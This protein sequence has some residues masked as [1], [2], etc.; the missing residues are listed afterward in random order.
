M[1]LNDDGE[2]TRLNEEEKVEEEEEMKGGR[3]IRELVATRVGAFAE[4]LSRVLESRS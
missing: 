2:R 1:R 3:M 4:S